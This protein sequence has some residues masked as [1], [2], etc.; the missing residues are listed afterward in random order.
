MESSRTRSALLQE[1]VPPYRCTEGVAVAA[2]ATRS[3]A[4]PVRA[5][6]ER[7]A[8]DRERSRRRHTSDTPLANEQLEAAKFMST[9][10]IAI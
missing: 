7:T 4:V 9:D 10:F 3:A 1:G 2:R 6:R 8:R 5:E